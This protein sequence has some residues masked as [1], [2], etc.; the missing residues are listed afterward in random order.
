MQTRIGH[1]VDVEKF[2]TRIPRPPKDDLPQTIVLSCIDL[3]NHRRNDVRRHEVVI[4]ARAIQIRRHDRKKPLPVL[5]M[6]RFAHLE[7]RN[8]RYRI[9]LIRRLQ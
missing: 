6:N 7:P 9:R 2:P 8:L 1:V 5:A 4:I 3:A